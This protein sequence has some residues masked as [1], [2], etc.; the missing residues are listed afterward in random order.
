MRILRV[1]M[2]PWLFTRG[3]AEADIHQIIV[4]ME[5]KGRGKNRH[6]THTCILL[7]SARSGGTKGSMYLSF[8]TRLVDRI[9]GELFRVSVTMPCR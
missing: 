4:R 2:L 7:S 6:V 5:L 3:R 1:R 9:S 8:M